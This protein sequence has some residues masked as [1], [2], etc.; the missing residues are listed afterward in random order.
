MI[1]RTGDSV[2]HRH[3]IW[4][5]TVQLGS[6]ALDAHIAGRRVGLLSNPASIDGRFR[7]IVD[8]VAGLSDVTLAALFGPQHGFRADVQDNMIETD[9]A[10]HRVLDVPVY[11][12]YGDTREPTPEM[13]ADLDTLVVDLQDVGTRVYTYIHTLANCLK[14]CQRADVSVVVC[15]RPNP[16]GG[17]EVEGPMLEPGFE[18]FVG[19]FPVP[20]R[21]GLTIGEMARL[22]NDAFGIGAELDVLT[23]DGWRRAMF[24]DDTGLPWVLPSPNLPTLEGAIVYPGMVLLEGTNLSEGR[25]T[26]RPFELFGAPWLDATGLAEALNARRLPGAH[27]R[28]TE[29]LPTFQKHAGTTCGGCQLHVIDRLRFRP[30]ETAVTVLALC[31]AQA[32]DDFGWREPPYEYEA[33]LPPIDILAGSARIRTLIDADADGTDLRDAIEAGVDAF[34]HTRGRYLLY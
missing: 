28:P 21:H 16:I 8:H 22:C 14:A 18:S 7:H 33:L 25:G 32:P 26:T 31:R 17:L 24:H 9:H 3:I 13:L 34:R 6:A 2:P 19:L 27:F 11:S 4:L 12:L 5:V 23:M 10:R 29:F 30:V 1:A 15:D 20:L